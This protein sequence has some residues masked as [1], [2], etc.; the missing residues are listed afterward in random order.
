MQ[1][2]F[3]RFMLRK[4][5]TIRAFGASDL[6]VRRFTWPKDGAPSLYDSLHEVQKINFFTEE[7]K[8]CPMKIFMIFMNEENTKEKVKIFRRN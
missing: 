8:S 5:H 2:N 3:K 6:E 4:L 7:I 1:G